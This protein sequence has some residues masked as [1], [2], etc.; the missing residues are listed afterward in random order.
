MKLILKHLSLTG[1]SINLFE[2]DLRFLEDLLRVLS[3]IF[4]ADSM[5]FV[6][7]NYALRAYVYLVSLA[8]ILNLF[9]WMLQTKLIL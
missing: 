3:I 2:Q 6:V 9:L 7:G 4:I 1:A 5:S 8:E